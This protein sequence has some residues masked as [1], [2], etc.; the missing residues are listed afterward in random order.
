MRIAFV[1]CICTTLNDDQPVW[2]WLRAQRPD[3]LVLLGDSIYLDLANVP[4]LQPENLEDN[5][6]AKLLFD[7]YT[8]LATQPQFLALVRSMPPGSVHA[9][10]DDHDFLWNDTCGANLHPLHTGKIRL[11][12]AFLEVF[13]AALAQ[14]L[15]PDSFPSVYNDP[16]FW[17]E[18]QPALTTP[19]IELQPGL[20]LHLSDGRTFRTG[21]VLIP[22]SHRTLFGQAQIDHFTAA[23]EARPQAIHLWASGSTISGYKRYARDLAWLRKLASRQRMLVISGDI[24]RNE[25]D[26]FYT[27]DGGFP[28]HEAT[29]SGVA[30]RDGV[31]FGER[32]HNHGLLDIDDEQV[33]IRTF[34]RN[35]QDEHRVLDIAR[36]LPV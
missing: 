20:W 21:T 17:N 24:H 31:V 30:V 14:S 35:V 34:D 27:V 9:I 19:S 2:D 6:F 11:A 29:S 16:R 8:E 36:W 23:I 12:T 5:D 22:E 10:W 25:L 3:R 32:L 28:M 1:S 15:A 7:R 18:A 33:T 4:E 13:R 26:A